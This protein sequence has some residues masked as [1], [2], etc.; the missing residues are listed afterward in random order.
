MVELS[1]VEELS[2]IE[3]VTVEQFL[4]VE[5]FMLELSLIVEFSTVELSIVELSSKSQLPIVTTGRAMLLSSSLEFGWSST[6]PSWEVAP[7]ESSLLA[8]EMMPKLNIINRKTEKILFIF[9]PIT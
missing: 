3:L 9:L 8:Q 6:S 2:T 1:T 5:S 7:E 4:T